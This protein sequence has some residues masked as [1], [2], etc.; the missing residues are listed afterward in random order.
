MAAAS[1]A[2]PAPPPAHDPQDLERGHDAVTGR[3]VLEDDH[4]A[5]LLAAQAGARHL[6]PLEDVLVADRR[7]DDQPAGRLDRGLEPAVGQDR[8]DEHPA[9]QLPAFEAIEGED[10]EDLVA[11]DHPA[12]RRRPR[13]AGRRRRRGRS[14]RRRPRRPP[15]R[16]AT[17][18]RSLRRRTLML[19]PSGS[20]WMTLT[21]APVAARISG[22]T[23]QPDPLAPS[24]TRRRPPAGT[25]VARPSRW[26]R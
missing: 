20:A 26:R 6:H 16:P 15:P 9:G 4:M 19:T 11:V 24:R 25:L 17:R 5:A 22:P 8:H 14:R 1:S 18:A 13:S 23:K 12:R 3:R 10:A 2:R 21:V 7:P